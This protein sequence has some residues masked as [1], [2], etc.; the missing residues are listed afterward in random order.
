VIVTAYPS[1]VVI[2]TDLPELGTVPANVTVPP[3]GAGT[4]APSVPATSMPRCCPPEYGCAGSKSNCWRTS[5]VAGH[6]QACAKGAATS[7]ARAARKSKTR[8]GIT[9]VV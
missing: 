9:S 8:I 4:G 1:G 3:A 5:P 6:V 7:A 2:V